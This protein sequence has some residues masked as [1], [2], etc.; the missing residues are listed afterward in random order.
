[1]RARTSASQ[2]RK[3]TSLSLLV[4]KKE[5][6]AAARSLEKRLLPGG[7]KVDRR[8]ESTGAAHVQADRYLSVRASFAPRSAK[9]AAKLRRIQANTPGLE[10]TCSRTD[11]AK[12]P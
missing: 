2:A 7:G 9:A 11:A 3:P 6:M 8:S 4:V 5:Y 1:M 10:I 12:T